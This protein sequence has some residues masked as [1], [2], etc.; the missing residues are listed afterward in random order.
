ML[1]EPSIKKTVYVLKALAHKHRYKI[2]MILLT[3]EKNVTVINETIQTSQ[4][5]LSQHLNKLKKA[6]IVGCRRE[7]RKIFYYLKD[8]DITRLM[9]I[10]CEIGAKDAK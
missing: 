7:Q 10:A 6:G 3:G 4:P 8:A 1:L 9:G 5:S 2:V